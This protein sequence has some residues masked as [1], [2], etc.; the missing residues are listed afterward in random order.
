VQ[1]IVVVDILHNIFI[2]G[3]LFIGA[4]ISRKMEEAISFE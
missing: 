2:A 1:I 3:I 4:G